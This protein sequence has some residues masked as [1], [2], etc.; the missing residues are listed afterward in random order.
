MPQRT[1]P[2]VLKMAGHW[3]WRCDHG[4]GPMGDTLDPVDWPDAYTAVLAFA[5]RHY[6]RYHADHEIVEE[7]RV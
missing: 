5:I 4:D 2:E 1:K 6:E 3:L 7:W